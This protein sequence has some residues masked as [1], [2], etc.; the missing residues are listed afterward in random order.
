MYRN[1]QFGDLLKY[2]AAVEKGAIS[3]VLYIGSYTPG[4]LTGIHNLF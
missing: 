1:E 2:I 4:V 3:A